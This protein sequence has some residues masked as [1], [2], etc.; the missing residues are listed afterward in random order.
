MDTTSTSHV[1]DEQNRAI[2]DQL[3]RIYKLVDDGTNPAFL[4]L[5]YKR[6]VELISAKYMTLLATL[7]EQKEQ[8]GEEEY[9]KREQALKDEYK[10]DVVLLAVSI[11]EATDK[12]VATE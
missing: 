4:K 9:Q 3:D 1:L 11:D 6:A 5:E 2:Q 7:A 8:L 10:E 12:K